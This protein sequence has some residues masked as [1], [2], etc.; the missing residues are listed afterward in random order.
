MIKG[1]FQ[2]LKK[3]FYLLILIILDSLFWFFI[4]LS[5][6]KFFINLLKRKSWRIINIKLN[7]NTTF[8]LIEKLIK[9]EKILSKRRFFSSCLSRSTLF[10][11]ILEIFGIK[12]NMFLGMYLGK[13]Q[14]KIPHAWIEVSKTGDIVTSKIENCTLIHKI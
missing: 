4:H 7:K 5:S 3:V 12:T 2:H 11:I 8:Y 1:S 10:M 9:Y 13:N 6:S 14:K